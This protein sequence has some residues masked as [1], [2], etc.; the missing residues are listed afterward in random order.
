MPSEYPSLR[1]LLIEDAADVPENFRWQGSPCCQEFISLFGVL[2]VLFPEPLFRGLFALEINRLKLL[3]RSPGNVCK[4][5]RSNQV[6][7]GF[8]MQ[9]CRHSSIDVVSEYDDPPTLR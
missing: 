6:L 8:R 7:K 1:E 3:E 5:F 9:I 4:F 2:P